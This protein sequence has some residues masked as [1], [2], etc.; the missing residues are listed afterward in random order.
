MQDPYVSARNEIEE[1]L[2]QAQ[3]KL[4]QLQ[5]SPQDPTQRRELKH[6]LVSIDEALDDV[7]ATVK[8]VSENLQRFGI[9]Q[10]EY[11]S[12]KAFVEDA[13]ARLAGL[14]DSLTQQKQTNKAHAENI[15]DSIAPAR[16]DPD[17]EVQGLLLEQEAA[18]V[19]QNRDL[20]QLGDAVNRIKTIGV[21]VNDELDQQDTL[22]TKMGTAVDTVTDRLKQANRKIDKVVEK[23]SLRK[24]YMMIACLAIILFILCMLT[25]G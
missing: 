2:A 3:G 16:A 4:Q 18:M 24:Q 1:M 17:V 25:I 20:E 21:T 7:R 15:K 13:S 19:R 9:T 11:Q 6:Q 14:R 12:R 5:L 22:L 8:V 10:A 23:M